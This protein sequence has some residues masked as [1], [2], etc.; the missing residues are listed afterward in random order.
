VPRPALLTLLLASTLTIM[1]GA[2]ISP[3]L[4]AM[5]RHFAGVPSADLLVRLVLT[6]TALAIAV[7]APA[8]GVLVDRWGRR[9]VLA[10]AIC[11]YA[12]GGGSGLVVDDLYA[13]LAGRVLLGV[14]V[15]G[16]MTAATA[17]LVDL[18][19][20]ADRSRVLGLQAATMGAGGVVFLTVGG[21]LADIDWRGPFAVY[22]AALPLAALSWWAVCEPP[23]GGSAGPSVPEPPVSGAGGALPLV[24][25]V[26]AL[27][28]ITQVIFYTVPTL[29]PFYLA[30]VGRIGATGAGLSISAMVAVSAV[31]SW[32]YARVRRRLGHPHV[33]VT[34]FA[35]LTAGMTGLGLA[36][37][38]TVMLAA[39]LV[40]GAGVGLVMPNFSAWLGSATGPDRR[41]RVLGA[42]VSLMFLGQFCSPLLAQP[43][44]T[45][46]GLDAAY[47]AAGAVAALAALGVAA[48][49]QRAGP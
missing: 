14:A 42:M 48:L 41:G 11:L 32:N 24:T 34:S 3:S 1:A 28:F 44:V 27:A 33:A 43:V 46:G 36:P 29:L 18:Y 12:V 17:L 23:R 25:A 15:A 4:P 6:A 10:G 22:L 20:G 35:L 31:A 5:A 30:E 40:T 7:S 47:L 26:C 21:V 16:V 13:I 39:L 37:D 45:V 19:G 9:P 2:T 49:A 8:A 38:A